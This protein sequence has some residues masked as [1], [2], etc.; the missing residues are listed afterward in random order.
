MHAVI[1]DVSIN[2]REAAQRELS[3]RVVP[4]VSQAPGF[5]AG[6]WLAVSEN[7]GHSIVVFES[8]EGA[9]TAA[10]AVQSNAPGAVTLDGVTV[11]E[12]V[13]QA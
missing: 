12:V 8:E 6:Y 13:A 10:E 4:T 1:V 5:V 7:K 2:D 9:R 3:E 11:A